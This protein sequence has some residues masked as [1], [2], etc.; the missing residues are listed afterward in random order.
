MTIQHNADEN[1][2]NGG[3][4]ESRKRPHR[5]AANRASGERPELCMCG[6]A[7]DG[8]WGWMVCLASFVVNFIQDGTVF[9]FG[10]LLL[11][12]LDYFGEGKAKTSWAGSSLLGMSMFM[13]PVVSLLLER[14][15]WRQVTLAGTLMSAVAFV[16]SVFSPNIDVLIITY[17]IIGGIGFSMS[18][19]SCVIVVGVY[20]NRKRAIA[21]GIAMSGSGL[22]TFVYAYL[23]DFLIQTYD[24]RGTILIL[25]GILLNGVV[26]GLL[27]RP[28]SSNSSRRCSVCCAASASAAD[29]KQSEQRRLI[30]NGDNTY[31][32]ELNV[33]NTTQFHLT[34]KLSGR[35]T[36][37]NANILRETGCLSDS[38]PGVKAF[39]SQRDLID[40]QIIDMKHTMS[41]KD[42]FYSGSLTNIR[43]K[44]STLVRCKDVNSGPDV[45]DN[46]ISNVNDSF[47]CGTLKSYMALFSDRIFV[48]LLLKDVCWTV[49]S[50]PLTY[51]PDLG[52]S[53]GLP[54]TQAATL[55][56][57]IGVTNIVGRVLSGVIT[58]VLH[59]TCTLTYIVTL[60][61]ASAM[62][63]L[64]PLCRGFAA[65]GVCCAVF[66]L[67]MATHVSMR[68]IVLADHLG[69]DR[70]TKSFGLVALFQGIAFVTNAPLAGFL[71]EQTNSYV[72]P[73]CFSG[74]M[75]FL[76]GSLCLL[77]FHLNRHSKN[78]IV[79]EQNVR[80]PVTGTTAAME[81]SETSRSGSSPGSW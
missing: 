8:G 77:V 35:L 52:V 74:A 32:A 70:L 19:I 9:S 29:C 43:S 2:V 67:C 75:Y 16:V 5:A 14:F 31:L 81:A 55:I 20:F 50:V 54:S 79:I 68:T 42:I 7:P 40:V 36:Q 80:L 23:T 11:E 22:G 3:H 47:L 49:Q 46:P 69:I 33:E 24:W 39:L 34:N 1:V 17:G 37:S 64:M 71:F 62:N 45:S 21:T 26:C 78:E 28:L 30:A 44:D 10:V 66:G 73:F 15:S 65:L 4:I 72:P 48:L 76:S 51:I 6:A 13:G 53:N 57:I 41:Q 61:A 58:D 60:F 25:A 63:F 18:F 38:S 12:L 56:S 59:V 27:Y